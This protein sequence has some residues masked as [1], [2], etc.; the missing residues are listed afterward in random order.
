MEYIIVIISCY[1]LGSISPAMIAGK[2]LRNIDIRDV[3]SKNAGTSNIAMT[4]GLKWGIAVGVS[5]ILKGLIPVV[6]LRIIFPENDIIWVVGGISAI[7]GHI[8]PFHMGFKGG[9]G[10]A[11]FGG[12]LLGIAPVFALVLAVVFTIVLFLS[13]YIAISTLVVLIVSPLGLYFLDFQITSIIL[14]SSY[15]LL[16]FYKHYPNYKRILLRQEIGLRKAFRKWK[17]A[18]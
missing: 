10:T 4:L 12:V 5:D 16:S 2:K 11:T 8:Y 1:L 6:I 17:E 14:I 7:L 3:N 18:N 15:S 13:D 9:K